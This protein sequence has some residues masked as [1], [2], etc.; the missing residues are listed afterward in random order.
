VNLPFELGLGAAAFLAAV[1]GIAA[2]IRGYSGFGFAALVVSAAGL[3][4]DPRH[5]VPVVLLCDLAMAIQLMQGLRGHIDWSRT[6]ALSGGAILGVPF[7][8]WMLAGADADLVRAGIA[9]FILVMCA[10]LLSGWG[11]G[12]HIGRAGTLTAGIVSGAANAAAVGGL[13]VAAFF[14]AQPVT[15][16]RFRATLIVYF[17]FLDL[18]S[19]PLMGLSGMV[20]RDTWIAVLLSL[21]FVFLGNWLGGRHFL[22]ADPQD[23]RKMAIGLLSLLALL[24]L[25]K[26]IW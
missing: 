23:F 24:G 11:F 1:F 18:L 4:T 19:V 8:L 14:A 25:M 10:A 15:A 26:S 7:G 6:G 12:R 9:V 20:T 5:M 22:R 16:A 2:F 21:P 3:V 13:P 17:I